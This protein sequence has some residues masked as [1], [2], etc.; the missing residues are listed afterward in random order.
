MEGWGR[1]LNW[2]EWVGDK[3]ETLSV[4]NVENLALDRMKGSSFVLIGKKDDNLFEDLSTYVDFVLRKWEHFLLKISILFSQISDPF[5][6]F[7]HRHRMGEEVRNL[8]IVEKLWNS[9]LNQE[10]F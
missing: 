10:T 7:L 5:S 2:S 8:R 9:D 4:N 6:H 1:K 3:E